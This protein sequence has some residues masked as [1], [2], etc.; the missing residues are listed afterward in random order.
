MRLVIGFGLAVSCWEHAR[1]EETFRYR[2]F[3]RRTSTTNHHTQRILR[4]AGDSAGIVEKD[5]TCGSSTNG[6]PAS[7]ESP[8]SCNV[9]PR[10]TRI[11]DAGRPRG[12]GAAAL[13][14]A[15]L[16]QPDGGLLQHGWNPSPSFLQR[17]HLSDCPISTL[18]CPSPTIPLDY[19]L[20]NNLAFTHLIY[21]SIM[22][23]RLATVAPRS[24]GPVVAPRITPILSGVHQTQSALRTSP[25][26]QRRG[27]HEKDMFPFTL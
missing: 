14:I 22:F 18:F 19:H 12:D 2:T 20:C 21:L 3:R 27:Y 25:A 1:R 7:S 10:Q 11:A 9:I 13:G 17:H 16:S 24:F 4:W 8:T 5:K 15:P 6:E 26:P 23:K